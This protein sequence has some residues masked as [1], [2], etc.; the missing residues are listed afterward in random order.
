MD[1]DFYADQRIFHLKSELIRSKREDGTD[2][3]RIGAE[4]LWVKPATGKV[5]KSN[6]LDFQ[7]IEPVRV[8]DNSDAYLS[9]DVSIMIAVNRQLKEETPFEDLSAFTDRNLFL[10]EGGFVPTELLA[11]LDPA[12]EYL[13][14]EQV[15]GRYL[16]RLRFCGQNEL[17]LP[18]PAELTAYLS[19]GTMKGLRILDAAERVLKTGR[20]L[21][22][23]DVESH[24]NQEVAAS[25]LRLFLNKRTNPRG[26]VLI[27]STHCP[28]LL[29]EPGRNDAVFLTRSDHGLTVDNLNSLLKRN[30]IKRSEIYQSNLLGGTAPQYAVWAALQKSII[31][32]LKK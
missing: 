1:I 5:N 17:V 24:L 19:S 18:D 6:L 31:D 2:F 26:A 30:D 11:F 12:I 32:D 9:E 22:A 14:F 28:G 29:D 8:R 20:H 23:D 27:F 15:N 7:G 3:T 25:L 4:T 21:I 13:R 16:T 10:P